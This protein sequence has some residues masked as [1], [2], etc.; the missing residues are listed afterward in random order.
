MDRAPEPPEPPALS[1]AAERFAEFVAQVEDGETVD[2]A[3][4]CAATPDLAPEL[5][6]LHARWLALFGGRGFAQLPVTAENLASAEIATGSDDANARARLLRDLTTVGPGRPRYEVGEEVARGGMA[7]ILRAH[8]RSLRRQLAMKVLLADRGNGNTGATAPAIDARA[9]ARFLD[10]AQ[11]TGQ[12]DHPGI[13]PVHEL[14][15]DG[16]GR[17]YF[18]MPLIRGRTLTAIYALVHQQAEQ[19]SLPRAIAVLQRVCETVAYA[20]SRGVIHRDLKPANVMVGRFGETYVMDWGLAQ[21]RGA[22]TTPPATGQALASAILTSRGEFADETPD[23]PLRTLDGHVVGTPAYMAPEQARGE[24]AAIGPTADVYSLGAMLYELLARQVPYVPPGASLSARTVLARVM[25]GPPTPLRAIDRSLPPELVTICE[26]AMA[27]ERHDRYA[28]ATELAEDLRAWIEGRVVRAHASGTWAELRKWIARNRSLTA[29]SVALVVALVLGLVATVALNRRANLA[30]GRLG[31]ELRANNIERGRLFLQAGNLPQA[32]RLLWPEHLASPNQADT[33][34]GLWDLHSRHPCTATCN[35]AVELRGGA[36]VDAERS[37]VVGDAAGTLRVLDAR[38]LVPMR[39]IDAPSPSPL[40]TMTSD[41]NAVVFSTHEDLSLHVTDVATGRLLRTLRIGAP[42]S[43]IAWCGPA[44]S[45]LVGCTDGAVLLYDTRDWSMR[46]MPGSSNSYVRKVAWNRSGSR[47]AITTTEALTQVFAVDSATPIAS[48]RAAQYVNSLCFAADDS[49]LFG[50]GNERMLSSLD[51]STGATVKLLEKPDLFSTIAVR[52]DGG[53]LVLG[54]L[55]RVD[56]WSLPERRRTRS[57]ELPPLLR[58]MLV[59]RAHRQAITVHSYEVRGWDLADRGRRVLT[60]HG[61]RT[62]CALSR[63]GSV[64]LTGDRDG[65]VRMLHRHG[66]APLELL[67]Q[68]RGRVRTVAVG[69]GHELGLSG[70]DDGVLQLWDLGARRVVRS[71]AD[72]VGASPQ[73]AGFAAD[74]RRIAFAANRQGRTLVV[75]HDLVDD[76]EVAAIEVASSQVIGVTFSP[77]GRQLACTARNIGALVFDTAGRTTR[78]LT[79]EQQSWGLAF[80]PDGSQLAVSTWGNAVEVFELATAARRTRLLNHSGPV[81][82][83]GWVRD[84]DITCSG[85]ADGGMQ[86]SDLR[87]GRQLLRLEPFGKETDVIAVSLADDGSSLAMSG[88]DGSVVVIDV[89]HYDAM[90][91]ANLTAQKERLAGPGTR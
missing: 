10:E 20:H 29:A 57:I 30:L 12:L 78:Q 27:R 75:V 89:L 90:I 81:W 25:A 14:G 56:A 59:D 32:E 43:A 76:R 80:R 21:V 60:G 42:A 62:T 28:T 82:S 58:T 17:V 85:S 9:L 52:D 47:L 63:D 79:T 19:W 2:F 22:A 73:S 23:A 3:A 91:D 46:R 40:T 68:H 53:Q 87:T 11:I 77:D 64:L 39:S 69:R 48:H 5:Q 36:W 7:A 45:L 51:P 8:D 31:D 54:G 4:F 67:G 24:L 72:F 70:G 44:H 49:V 66:D 65:A 88:A 18:T 83:V 71:F 16:H 13:P 86:L 34:W 15:I 33:R 35:M 61:G 26:K 38:T 74:G 55:Q 1:P 37:L 6:R 84:Q 41:G 50:G